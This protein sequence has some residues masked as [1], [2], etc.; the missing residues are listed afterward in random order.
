MRFLYLLRFL[1]KPRTP[2]GNISDGCNGLTMF[3][4]IFNLTS[5]IV[6]YIKWYCRNKA[7]NK[8]LQIIQIILIFRDTVR[9]KALDLSIIIDTDMT[10]FIA[11]VKN[12][13]VPKGIYLCI[14][15]R[16][17]SFYE[18]NLYLICS[19]RIELTLHLKLRVSSWCFYATQQLEFGT[20][21]DSFTVNSLRIA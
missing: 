6:K 17:I 2:H 5:Q 19:K 16:K 20:V 4:F 14:R 12:M 15:L 7:D 11:C 3:L 8:Y 21:Q 18:I 13:F 1:W 9:R 10:S